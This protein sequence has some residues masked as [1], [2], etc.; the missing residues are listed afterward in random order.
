MCSRSLK[1]YLL[2]DI[3]VRLIVFK[4]KSKRHAP[5]HLQLNVVDLFHLEK[6][7]C[8]QSIVS[9]DHIEWKR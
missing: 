3:L 8:G 4:L 9:P 1:M 2:K 6:T 5:D 7:I